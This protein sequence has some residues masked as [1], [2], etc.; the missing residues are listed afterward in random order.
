LRNSLLGASQHFPRSPSL[1]RN[2]TSFVA[3][4]GVHCSPRLLS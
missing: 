2:R 4:Q 3:F 1:V